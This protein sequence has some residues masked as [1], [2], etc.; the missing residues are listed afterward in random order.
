MAASWHTVCSYPTPTSARP[1]CSDYLFINLLIAPYYPP[2]EAAGAGHRRRLMAAAEGQLVGEALRTRSAGSG[3]SQGPA[4][5]GH[6]PQLV[7]A[8][9]EEELERRVRKLLARPKFTLAQRQ[10]AQRQ[11]RRLLTEGPSVEPANL[12]EAV[13]LPQLKARR[14]CGWSPAS[15]TGHARGWIGAG[16]NPCLALRRGLLAWPGELSPL[17]GASPRTCRACAGDRHAAQCKRGAAGRGGQRLCRGDGC[18][19]GRA[20]VLFRV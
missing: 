1:A 7:A 5:L 20:A 17:P 9:A 18:R 6:T 8:Q 3:D 12:P 15:M 10:P 4:S 19:G 16:L 14:S 13:E 11:H 2:G